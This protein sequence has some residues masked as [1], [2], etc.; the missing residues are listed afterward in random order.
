MGKMPRIRTQTPKRRKAIRIYAKDHN[1]VAFSKQIIQ[2]DKEL[3][4]N[5]EFPPDDVSELF[6]LYCLLEDLPD[7]E[8]YYQA[9]LPLEQVAVTYSRGSN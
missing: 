1:L 9:R 5:K 4:E 3:R 8:R 2:F 7:E 6:S